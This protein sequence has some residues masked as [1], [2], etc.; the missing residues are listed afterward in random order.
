MNDKTKKDY[1]ML[2]DLYHEA[3][4]GSLRDAE[5]FVRFQKRIVNRLPDCNTIWLLKKIPGES[6]KF[7]IVEE[8]KR[9]EGS[10]K[11]MKHREG[12]IFE[13]PDFSIQLF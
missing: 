6:E 2:H 4:E 1:L 9:T 12:K 8:W 7:T 5:N 13:M 10:W 3:L 11:Y